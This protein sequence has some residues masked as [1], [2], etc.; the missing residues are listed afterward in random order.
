[1]FI[2]VSKLSLMHVAAFFNSLEIFIFLEQKGLPINKKSDDLYL[3]IHY[4]CLKGCEKI[5]EYILSK[6]PTEATVLPP[7]K[8]HLIYL[9]TIGN[10]PAILKLL[11]KNG[12]DAK[13]PENI[14]NNPIYTTIRNSK[15][16][17]CLEI[18]LEEGLE[19]IHNY[20]DYSMLMHA[21][22]NN[23]DAATQLLLERGDDFEYVSKTNDNALSLACYLKKRSV[24]KYLC[25]HMTEIDIDPSLQ[26]RAAVHWIC[27]SGDVQI[28]KM[29]LA[30][31]IDVNR[32]D[33]NGNPGPFYLLDI[34]DEDTTLE[35][36]K[37]LYNAGLDLNI[38]GKSV[39]GKKTN[40]ILG[41]FVSS[42][43]R[44]TKVIEWLLKNGA[45]ADEMMVVKNKPIIKLVINGNNTRLK[46]LFQKCVPDLYES[47][48]NTKKK[49]SY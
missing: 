2:P 48:C 13:A 12:A 37:L 18:L 19:Y 42:I 26:R 33:Q 29:V 24:V 44:Q 49:S 32:I 36:L 7:V 22:S 35:I 30:K 4:A 8:Y 39:D 15:S 10:S 1:M 31:Y 34:C 23:N 27:L 20:T 21:I 16:S 3:P 5:V 25:D 9:A 45:R 46:L 40:T 17:E 41:H 43:Q 28:V 6:D 11:F 38:R 47:F 14:E